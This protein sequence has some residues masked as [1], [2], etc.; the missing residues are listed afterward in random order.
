MNIHKY[1]KEC[2]HICDVCDT[3]VCVRIPG[4]PLLR[5]CERKLALNWEY[6]KWLDPTRRF[7]K[8]L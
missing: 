6:P 1:I 4:L 2:A 7:S 8:S 5:K 3:C